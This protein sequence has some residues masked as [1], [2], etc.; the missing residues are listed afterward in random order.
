MGVSMVEGS[1]PERGSLFGVVVNEAF[2][3]QIGGKATGKHLTGSILNDTVT[4]VVANFKTQQLDSEPLPEVYVA[5][6]RLP[7]GRSLRIAVRTG[8]GAGALAAAV[9]ERVSQIDRTQALYEFQTLE[10]AL[11]DSVAP[12]RL[13]LF[14]LGIFA[15]TAL[16]L[17]LIGTYS[18]VAYSVSLRTRE[19]GV[20]LALG[21]GRAEIARMVVKQGMAIALCGLIAG[22]GIGLALT[23]LMGDLLYGV[24]PDDPWTFTL[25]GVVLG[26]TAL[27]ATMVPA[28]RAARV[29]PLMALRYE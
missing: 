14:L 7:F 25:A 11:A 26:V 20:R 28:L 13:N 22:T 12:R 1:W 10:E 6:E 4:G 9:N 15:A 17:A 5:Y 23:R 29:D 2:A 18:V 24:R 27:Y 3:R 8:P 16:L 21:A 19:I